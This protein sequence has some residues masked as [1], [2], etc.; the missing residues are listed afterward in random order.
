M[1]V[2]RWLWKWLCQCHNKGHAKGTKRRQ[3]SQ[4]RGQRQSSNRRSTRLQRQAATATAAAAATADNLILLASSPP[5]SAATAAA[6]NDDAVAA[7][8]RLIIHAV[9]TVA[10]LDDDA[11]TVARLDDDEDVDAGAGAGAFAAD[12]LILLADD[13]AASVSSYDAAAA[14][15]QQAD[16]DYLFGCLRGHFSKLHLLRGKYMPQVNAEGKYMLRRGKQRRQ[17]NLHILSELPYDGEF[18]KHATT[19]NTPPSAEQSN[20]G[21]TNRSSTSTRHLKSF[22]ALLKLVKEAHPK[23]NVCQRGF[24]GCDNKLAKIVVYGTFPPNG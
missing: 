17:S 2:C 6:D 1:R 8:A 13:A 7:A 16:A 19:T 15:K 20:Y 21:A 9:A 24:Q 23:A 22:Q 12:N 5:S 14:A 18:F 3:D 11:A 10:R 4:G